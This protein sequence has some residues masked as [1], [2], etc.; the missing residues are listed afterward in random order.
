[1]ARIQLISSPYAGKSVIASG[2]ECINLYA[3]INASLD[4]Q[5]P[6][7]TTYYPT[8][9]STVY[10]DPLFLKTARAS[11]RTSLDTAFYVVGQNVYFLSDN[12]VLIFIGAIADLQSQIYFSDNGQVAV[13]V[14]GVNGYVIDLP[15]NTLGI[16]TDPNFYGADYVVL[17]DTFF[18][19]NRPKT[20]QFYI[21]E[22]NASYGDLTNSSLGTGAIT[23]PG[24][25]GIVGLYQNVPLTGGSGTG[26]IADIQIAFGIIATGAI[27]AAG[28]GYVNGF[29][30]A[31][32]LSGGAGTG[33]TA[34]ITIAGGAV[35]VVSFTGPDDLFG[36]G[37]LVGDV[38]TTPTSDLGGGAG[39]G[40]TWTVASIANGVGGVTIDNPGINYLVGDV[41]SAASADIGNTINFTYTNNVAGSAFNPLDIAAK[42]GFNDPIVGLA[43]VHRE[44]WLIG[45][46]TTEV[47]IDTGAADFTFQEQ[48]GAYINHGCAAQYSIATMDVLV[49]FIM[50]DQQGNGI[51]VQG[52][53]YEV[54][55]IS[56]PRIVAE[57]KSYATL[58]DAIGFCFQIADHAFYCLVFPTANKGWLFDVGNSQWC[59]WN[60]IDNDGNFNRPRAN[61]CMFAYG[62]NL[63]GD[64]ENGQ[65][66]ELSVDVY[67]DNGQ[68]IVCVRTFPHD[69]DNNER[70]TTLNFQADMQVGNAAEGDDP[71]V[72]LSWSNNKGVSYGNPVLQ[73]LGKIGQ[74]LKTLS[75]NRLG[76]ARD[77]VFKL[78][79]A[80]NCKTALNGGF[81]ERKKART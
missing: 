22:S 44:L 35:T 15:T 58:T 31:V 62:V 37:Y 41:L 11:Y 17:L 56:T 29:Y 27:S 30:P 77:R 19:F 20:N 9:G 2:Q 24:T 6:S 7:Q 16:I 33:A 57:F 21:S 13:F 69:N 5:A 64:W 60:W 48:Q 26:A 14:D 10:A 74:F 28:S 72:S 81:I 49:F 65:L 18:I 32:P 73:P 78:S 25:G 36:S 45:A 42:S 39:A 59:E 66:L 80:A 8:P 43:S 55:E 46:L 79:W 1:M 51:V 68:P 34:D 12:Q 3:E 23:T 61:C 75:W 71:Q 50:Q 38:L 4:P 67:S 53:G 52:Q 40:F 47:W 63:V 76:Q 54:A 70:V